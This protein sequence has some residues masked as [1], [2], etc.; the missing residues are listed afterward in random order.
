MLP[1]NSLAR[2]RLAARA[3]AFRLSASMLTSA[4]SLI[5]RPTTSDISRASRS[6]EMACVKRR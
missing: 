6:N 2:I 1:D 4:P 3:K 5:S